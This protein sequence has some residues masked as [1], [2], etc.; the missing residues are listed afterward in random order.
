MRRNPE[1]KLFHQDAD[2]G[3]GPDNYLPA[4]RS[5]SATHRVVT[6]PH[7]VPSF[8]SRSRRLLHRHVHY[9]AGPIILL[10]DELDETITTAEDLDIYD[11]DTSEFE[12]EL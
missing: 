11:N 10:W 6:Q 4:N 3:S 8:H 5:N 1:F 9:S 2:N 12:D 7:L